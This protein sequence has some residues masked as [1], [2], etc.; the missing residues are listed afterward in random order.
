MQIVVCAAKFERSR[1]LET[2]G[3]VSDRGAELFA[4]YVVVKKRSSHCDRRE[5]LGRSS[6][7]LNSYEL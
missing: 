7:V 5:Y 3:L 1:A 6:Q 2:F 4:Q